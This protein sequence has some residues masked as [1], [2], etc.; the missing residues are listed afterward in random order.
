LDK[1]LLIIVDQD[2]VINHWISDFNKYLDGLG[3]G[4]A[5]GGDYIPQDWGYP[6]LNLPANIVSDYIHSGPQH[7]PNEEMILFLK[8]LKDQ[9]ND[10]VIVTSHPTNVTM[11]R[12]QNLNLYTKTYGKFFD[13]IAFTLAHDR[14]GKPVYYS[15]AD[16]ISKVYGEDNRVKLF[17]D[18]RLKN[19]NEVVHLNGKDKGLYLGFSVN[20]AY[21]DKDIAI[22]QENELLKKRVFLGQGDTMKK[23]VSDMIQKIKE[24]IKEV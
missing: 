11:E 10:I 16:Y 19:V 14:K 23:Q 8:D 9:G 7:S 21:N 15:K 17:I 18:D 3:L 20:R 13:H 22:L 12:L 2:D 5:L 1:K 6:E 4:Y 24:V